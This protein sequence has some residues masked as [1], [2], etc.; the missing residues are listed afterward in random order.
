MKKSLI[1]RWILI[2]LVV[3]GWTWSIFPIKDKS[4]KAEFE[5]Q[6]AKQVATSPEV[7][8]LYD[9]LMARVAEFEAA[10]AGEYA[11]FSKAAMG[12]DE[13]NQAP[14]RLDNFIKPRGAKDGV[15]N[16]RV[17]RFV[18]NRVAGKLKLGLDLQGGTE[19]VLG[20]DLQGASLPEGKTM[21]DIRDQVLEILRNRLNSTGVVEPEIKALNEETISV[22]MPSIDE[23]DKESIKDTLSTA[24]EL[25]FYLVATNNE[26]LVAAAK[27]DINFRHPADVI[28][29]EMI[30]ERD[31]QE[32]METIFLERN[33]VNLS[34]KDVDT[35]FATT[36]Q[37]GR[38]AISLRFKDRGAAS[39]AQI[40][41]ANVRRRLAIVL[42]NTVY[43]AP[44]INEAIN[45]GSAQI[46][47]SF[48]YE[49]ARRLA[50]VISA[51]NMP[52]KI[53]I[54]SE[55]GTD[56]TL[57]ADSIK[58][59]IMAG[60]VG[61]GLVVLFMLW[62]YRFAGLV[63]IIA[64]VVNAVL[65]LG[66]MALTKA[67][68]T[69]PGI[70]GMVLTIGMAVDANV[71]I[72][73]RIREELNK[74]KTIG[75]A[76]TSGYGKVF[77][78][79]FD[80]NLTTLITCFFLYK[81]G[82]GSVRGFAVTLA[83]G[84]LASMFTALFMT[85]AIFDL[86]I[87]CGLLKNLKMN[88]FGFLRNVNI[89]FFKLMKPAVVISVVLIVISLVTY[90]VRRDALRGIDFS[91]GT[92]LSYECQGT[93]PNVEE[94][95]AYLD[96]VGYENVK[97]G[98]R[99]GQGGHPELEVTLQNLANEKTQSFSKELDQKFPACQISLVSTYQVGGSVG[100]AFTKAALLSAFLAF[101]AVIIYLAFRFEFLYGVG[102]VVAV[103][104]D[105]VIA[106]GL[107]FLFH[108]GQLSLTV[109]AA[110]MTIIG[111]SLNDTIVIF[112]R[113]RETQELRKDLSYK[114]LVNR[115]VN[116]TLSRTMLTT[117]TT[118][119]TAGALLIFGGGVIFDFAIVMFYGL[120]CGTYS[121]VFVATAIVSKWHKKIAQDSVVEKP[122]EVEA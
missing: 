71:L 6:A 119:L 83:F 32:V 51:G 106:A 117:I 4:F 108:Q 37:Y 20:L 120:I 38:W 104:H 63:A 99:R 79:I 64:L 44:V 40:T 18:R 116:D 11:A 100:S 98:Y 22:S 43:S 23:G 46:S 48:T 45:G 65:V 102:A 15:N 89:D 57:G 35:A 114:Q 41:G 33:P 76:V 5:A 62:Y 21:V 101:I 34:G 111:Y 29:R 3:A 110:L 17:M 90:V 73:E 112:D 59:G 113:V 31:G 12:N 30:E 53:V 77:W 26:E 50:G 1:I 103:I 56:P 14:I 69:M 109:V 19:F 95:R 92:M 72:F 91:G 86:M 81:F 67:T 36:D 8:A 115:A 105:V 78:C 9:E 27:R 60:L 16:K 94:I 58:S 10:G 122:A 74:G 85:H 61:L 93:T 75:N 107:F 97:V 49:E 47:G 24:A 96:S 82:T 70:A 87:H 42:D 55:F 88:S 13:K 121:T 28:R 66:T 84:I 68:I 80:S 25:K 54:N 39:F 118:M 7:K 52:A 2:L